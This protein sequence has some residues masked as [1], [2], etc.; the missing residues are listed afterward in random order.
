MQVSILLPTR[1][2]LEYLKMAVDSVRRQDVDDWEIVISDNCS[3][4]DV[5]GYV[6]SLGDG[7]IIFA[8]QDSPVPVTENWNA[9]LALS[10]GDYVVMLGDDD[11]LMPGYLSRMAETVGRF[12]SPDLVYCNS[13]LFTYPGVDPSCPLGSV[14]PYGYAPFF[15]HRTEPFVL[16]PNDSRALV[17]ASMNFQASYAFN[18]QLALVSRELVDRLLGHG[19]LFR[20]EFPDYYAMNVAF[21]HAARLVID[22]KPQV[23]V[24]VTPNS[25]GYF[26]A[27]RREDEGFAFLGAQVTSPTP[28]SRINRGWLSAVSAI[29]ERYGQ[30]FG[31]RVNRRRYR[32]LQ[33]REVYER[34]RLGE[35]GR[36]EVVAF[37]RELPALERL[38]FRAVTLI[39]VDPHRVRTAL[40]R[41]LPAPVAQFTPWDPARD[42]GRYR[43]ILEVFDACAASQPIPDRHD[44]SP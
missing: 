30:S 29:E 37:S 34:R 10:S 44:P 7:R 25:Y 31:L 20:S 18:M 1:N 2:R 21:L 12:S 4:E 17:R 39:T 5:A 42:I 43:D 33:C 38:A 32:R 9:A 8:R 40:R 36:A 6:A 11:A 27:N 26:H 23:I 3:D 22:P 13:L 14:M 35:I 15:G 24:G 28:A 41:L 16:D 19:P